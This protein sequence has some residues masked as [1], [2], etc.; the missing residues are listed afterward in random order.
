MDIM[1][2]FGGPHLSPKGDQAA[3]PWQGSLGLEGSNYYESI[4]V[5]LVITNWVG[6]GVGR[7]WKLDV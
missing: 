2:K 5:W 6:V 7:I 4:I 3:G 1:V